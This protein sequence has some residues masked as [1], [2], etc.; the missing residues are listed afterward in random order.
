MVISQGVVGQVRGKEFF[1][2]YSLSIQSLGFVCR[3]ALRV[4][5]ASCNRLLF[6][7]NCFFSVGAEGW[8]YT[9]CMLPFFS[10][11]IK[12]NRRRNKRNV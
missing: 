2:V 11:A 6:S 4:D 5:T 8:I 1:T 9:S 10:A 12:R 3:T 7:S